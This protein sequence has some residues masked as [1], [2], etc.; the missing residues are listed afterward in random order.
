M[1]DGLK[2]RKTGASLDSKWGDLE[3]HTCTTHTLPLMSMWL[4]SDRTELWMASKTMTLLSKARMLNQLE[5]YVRTCLPGIIVLPQEF[6][7]AFASL[8]PSETTIRAISEAQLVQRFSDLA[9]SAASKGE[10]DKAVDYF[11]AAATLM[12][13]VEADLGTA[14]QMLEVT[15]SMVAASA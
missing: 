5:A 9:A 1:A 4:S 12:A 10:H 14:R 2:F 11:T 15:A 6:A 7:L 8:P 13:R 3:I